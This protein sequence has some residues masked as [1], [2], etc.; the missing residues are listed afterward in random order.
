MF[1]TFPLFKAIAISVAALTG[2]ALH[3]EACPKQKPHSA[4][5]HDRDIPRFAIVGFVD[6]DSDGKSDL[7]ALRRLIKL[8]GGLVDAELAVDGTIFG[9]LRSDTRRLILGDHPDKTKVSPK[10]AKQFDD[11]MRSAAELDIRVLHADKLLPY[12][13]VRVAPERDATSG[14]PARPKRTGGF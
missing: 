8:N 3:A 7:E 2:L 11:F 12:G 6:I 9:D 10:V 14:F 5:N 4:E 13:S 1:Q